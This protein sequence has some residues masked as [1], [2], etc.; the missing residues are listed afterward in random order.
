MLARRFAEELAAEGYA[1]LLPA[2]EPDGVPRTVRSDVRWLV[3]EG[4]P[5]TV[6]RARDLGPWAVRTGWAG[7]RPVRQPG[8]TTAD[9]SAAT[10]ASSGPPGMRSGRSSGAESRTRTSSP[11]TSIPTVNPG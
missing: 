10:V 1:V 6:R 4:A 7:L 11:T 5:W 2:A 8:V 9:P 3:A